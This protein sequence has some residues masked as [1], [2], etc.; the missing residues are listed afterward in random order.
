MESSVIFSLIFR[1]AR[2]A[3]VRDP[4]RRSRAGSLRRVYWP[5]K[6]VPVP[7]D[8]GEVREREREEMREEMRKRAIHC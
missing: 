5:K 6:A 2:P 3:G 8:V 7:G 1:D 4:G